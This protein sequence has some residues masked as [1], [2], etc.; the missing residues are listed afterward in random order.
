MLPV[1]S[2][3]KTSL[4]VKHLLL[5][6]GEFNRKRQPLIAYCRTQNITF[7]IATLLGDEHPDLLQLLF[8]FLRK[9]DLITRL[10]KNQRQTVQLIE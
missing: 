7:G 1:L 2:Q 3:A 4:T 8:D 6:F 5:Q 10:K 9:T